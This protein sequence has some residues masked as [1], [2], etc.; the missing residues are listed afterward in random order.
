MAPKPVSSVLDREVT[1]RTPENAMDHYEHAPISEVQQELNDHG[2][3][4]SPTIAKVKELVAQSER[5][6][7][8]KRR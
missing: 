7:V 8:P 6:P 3:D 2:I 4:A 1:A 5:T